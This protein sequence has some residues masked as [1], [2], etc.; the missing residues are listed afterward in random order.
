M[1]RDANALLD[2]AGKQI[3]DKILKYLLL[4]GLRT[5]YKKLS[6]DDPVLHYHL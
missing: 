4:D 5:G 6:S 2:D 1:C 3:S